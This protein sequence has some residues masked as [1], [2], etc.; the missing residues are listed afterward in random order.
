MNRH[1]T[2]IY[3][4]AIKRALNEVFNLD[5]TRDDEIVDLLFPIWR[6]AIHQIFLR[7]GCGCTSGDYA[8]CFLH[9]SLIEQIRLVPSDNIYSFFYFVNV[10]T[11]GRISF[12]NQIFSQECQVL[13]A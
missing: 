8:N 6:E 12:Y 11:K 9:L 5:L 7:R 3:N 2:A 10:I 1:A 4:R 13:N